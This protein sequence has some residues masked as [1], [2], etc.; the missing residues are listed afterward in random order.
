MNLKVFIIIIRLSILEEDLYSYSVGMHFVFLFF[1]PLFITYIFKNML[2]I[3]FNI[4]FSAPYDSPTNPD[5]PPATTIT[6]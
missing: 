3:L 5:L 6:T 1:K 2:F 4:D